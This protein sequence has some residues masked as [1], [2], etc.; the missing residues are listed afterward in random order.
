MTIWFILS[1]F[2]QKYNG[3]TSK[4]CTISH[5]PLR[6]I[7]IG[8]SP[9]AGRRVKSII[10]M[11]MN[12]PLHGV[13]A[14]ALTPLQADGGLDLDGFE[15]LLEFLSQ[16]GCHGALLFGTTGEG[17]SFSPLERLAALQR[18]AAW[19]QDHPDFRL[20]A[21]TGT[22]SLAETAEL[23]RAAF[24]LGM[25]GVVT[26]PPYYFRKVSDDGL[27]AWFAQ[28]IRQSVPAQG[29]FFG[30]HFPNVSGVPLSIE[31]LFR[32]KD[33]FP[34]QFA[35]IKDSSGDPQH[36]L[37]L[38]QRFGADLVVLTGN[39]GLFSLALQQQAS[40]CITAMANLYSP[41]L[42]RLWDAF[43]AGDL[44][45]VALA[46]QRL[47]DA[48]AVMDRYPPFPPLLKALLARQYGF[49]RW[50]VRPPLLDLSPQAAEQAAAEL[51]R[52]AN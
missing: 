48:R 11:A 46:Q 38:G 41:D 15:R 26:L 21:G 49:P 7:A 8:D 36:A 4:Y 51:G 30:Y 35:G 43:Q 37:A 50:P 22:P 18:A 3:M 42:R 29:A 20:L 34:E 32:L 27:F 33:A 24:D 44:A 16:R 10:I 52:I 1:G 5:K 28:V 6:L 40:G 14:A 19:R 2:G 45:T 17:P 39:D 13:F 25:D 31:L 12:Q 9:S 23:T 47:A